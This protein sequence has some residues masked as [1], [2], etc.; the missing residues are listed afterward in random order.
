VCECVSGG[1]FMESLKGYWS[2]RLVLTRV[3]MGPGFGKSS[4]SRRKID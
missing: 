4:R 1:G 3:C 2:N